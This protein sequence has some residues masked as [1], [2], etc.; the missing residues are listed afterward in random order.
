MYNGIHAKYPRQAPVQNKLAW[1]QNVLEFQILIRKH[2]KL[3]ESIET[4]NIV[5]K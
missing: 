1:L 4:K 2:D 3:Y 5:S